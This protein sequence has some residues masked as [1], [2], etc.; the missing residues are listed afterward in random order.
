MLHRVHESRTSL[1]HKVL[2]A[3]Y[4]VLALVFLHE[5][6][7]LKKKKIKKEKTRELPDCLARRKTKC[8]KI[9]AV[10]KKNVHGHLINVISFF[11]LL[12]III[13]FQKTRAQRSF[14]LIKW[15]PIIL[16]FL[17]LRAIT[18]SFLVGIVLVPTEEE[19]LTTN[20]IFDKPLK[21]I[22]FHHPS[23]NP[24]VGMSPE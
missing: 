12:I 21:S 4:K 9:A 5:I 1:R 6:H 13:L 10:K 24:T 7:P 20:P 11:F 2:Q 18:N 22:P 8:T 17:S 19:Y 3:Q 14:F 15:T 16:P 23:R